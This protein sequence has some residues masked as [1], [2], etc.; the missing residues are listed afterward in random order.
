M[1]KN[2]ESVDGY[3]LTECFRIAADENETPARRKLARDWAKRILNSTGGGWEGGGV[4]RAEAAGIEV[5]PKAPGGQ[6]V[7]VPTG[8]GT[9]GINE[10]AQGVN[11]FHYSGGGGF[12]PEIHSGQRVHRG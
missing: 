1:T 12:S 8:A 10:Q 6:R 3:V 9:G 11:E 2:Q 7:Y 4:T 5:D